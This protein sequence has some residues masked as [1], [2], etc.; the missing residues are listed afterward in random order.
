MAL[1]KKERRTRIKLKIRK[2]ISGTATL[3]RLSIFRSNTGIYAQ[4]IDDNNGKTIATAS[5][6]DKSLAGKKVT[7][8]EQASTVGKMI[9]E[10]A[11]TT[12]ITNV[13]FDR[14]G[15][16]YHGRIKSLADG[17]RSAGLVF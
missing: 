4:L 2:K 3:P 16:L 14:S 12:G 13:V 10:K 5:S 8:L 17:A 11:K 15:Y 9:A 7:K 6:N 1:T